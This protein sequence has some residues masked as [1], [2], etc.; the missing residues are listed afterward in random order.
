M[1]ENSSEP[2]EETFSQFGR[3]SGGVFWVT[4]VQE[5]LAIG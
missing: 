3:E 2:P 4:A 1:D 5:Q